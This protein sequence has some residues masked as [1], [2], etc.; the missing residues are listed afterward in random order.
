ML[1][2]SEQ[3][4]EMMRQARAVKTQYAKIKPDSHSASQIS[5]A[6][7]PKTTK[8][9]HRSTFGNQKNTVALRFHAF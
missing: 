1:I 2:Q 3:S 7:V 4:Q 6:A 8:K 9:P 5:T